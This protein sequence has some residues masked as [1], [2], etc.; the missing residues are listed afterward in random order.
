MIF[1]YSTVM[2]FLEYLPYIILGIVAGFFLYR[3]IS[4]SINLVSYKELREKFDSGEKFHL[5]DVRSGKEFRSGFIAGAINVPQEKIP[6]GLKKKIKKDASIIL[7]CQSGSRANH[8][9][10]KMEMSGY[11]NVTS[12]GGIRRWK[13][14]LEKK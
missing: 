12:F 1:L 14:S 6:T 8:A 4:S 10:R 9:K 11:T 13:G 3:K 5:I 7:Y 2:N